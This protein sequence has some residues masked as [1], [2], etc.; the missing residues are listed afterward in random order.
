[1]NEMENIE[2]YL[3]SVRHDLRNRITVIREGISC[4]VDGLGKHDCAKCSEM[5]KLSLKNADELNKL[6]DELLSDS[7]IKSV[8]K[9]PQDTKTEQIASAKDS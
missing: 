7:A 3:L 1:M 9:H 8:L 5:L 4:V 6:L 2:E